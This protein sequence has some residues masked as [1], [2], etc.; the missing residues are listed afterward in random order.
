MRGDFIHGIRF[1]LVMAALVLRPGATFDPV[2]FAGWLDAQADLSPKWRPTHIRVADT[3][4]T[5]PTNKV[6]LRTLAH[7]KYRP[8]RVGGDA[9]WVRRRADP[10]YRPF[11]EAEADELRRKLVDNGRAGFW[12]L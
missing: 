2:T 6:L 12:D 10:A 3:I 5:S 1:R 11:G 4:P 8:D 9:L 7:E